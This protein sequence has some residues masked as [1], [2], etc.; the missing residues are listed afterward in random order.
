MAKKKI[1]KIMDELAPTPRKVA[2]RLVKAKGRMVTIEDLIKHLYPHART[3]PKTAKTSVRNAV[4]LMRWHGAK[5]TNE[6]GVGYSL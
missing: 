2:E 3:R 6:R 1:D 4:M 5:V